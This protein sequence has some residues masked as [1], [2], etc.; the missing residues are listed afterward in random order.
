M[1]TVKKLH[2]KSGRDPGN[3]TKNM[4]EGTLINIILVR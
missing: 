1:A 2:T 3:P 4:E